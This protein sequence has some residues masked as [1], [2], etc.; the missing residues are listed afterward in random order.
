MWSKVRLEIL[1]L[2]PDA[3]LKEIGITGA[4]SHPCMYVSK[5]QE[6]LVIGINVDEIPLA[7]RKKIHEVTGTCC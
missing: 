3:R 6:P 7:G 1:E 5:D 2:H 4:T